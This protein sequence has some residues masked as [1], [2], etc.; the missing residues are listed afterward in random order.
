MLKRLFA[1]SLLLSTLAL[2][3]CGFQQMGEAS[4]NSGYQWTSLY[5]QDVHTSAVP[6]FT[7]VSYTRGDEFTLTKAIISQIEQRTPYKVVD[8]DK[9]DTI[10]EGQITRVTR[11]TISSDRSSSLPQ[12]QL[13]VVRVNFTWKDLRTGQILVE[14][15]DFEQSNPFYPTLGEGQETGALNTVEQLALG[16]VQELQANW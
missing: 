12:E 9:A 7:N 4:T 15:R 5:R 11:Q 2:S 6:I 1:C 16:I 10:L 14:R 13:Y 3:G 8:R